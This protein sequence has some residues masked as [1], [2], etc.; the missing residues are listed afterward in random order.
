MGALSLGRHSRGSNVDVVTINGLGLDSCRLIKV[1]VE[2]T[3]PDI[4]IST[5]QIIRRLQPAFFV[6]NNQ[7]GASARLAP[8][9]E[10]I[11]YRAFYGRLIFTRKRRAISSGLSLP[12][13]WYQRRVALR[14]PRSCRRKRR[15]SSAVGKPKALT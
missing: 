6:E 14:L 13:L 1:D 9:F 12:R 15:A 10:E 3:E 4:L 8:I 7:P 11:G 5:R 2:G